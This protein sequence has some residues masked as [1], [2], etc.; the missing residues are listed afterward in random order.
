MRWSKW[1]YKWIVLIKISLLIE[2]SH[3]KMNPEI[4]LL[5][6]MDVKASIKRREKETLNLDMAAPRTIYIYNFKHHLHSFTS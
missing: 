1:W 4:S 5:Y 2:K 6:F 3:I